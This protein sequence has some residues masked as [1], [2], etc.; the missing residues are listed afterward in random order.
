MLPENSGMLDELVGEFPGDS[1]YSESPSLSTE[2]AANV[3]SLSGLAANL[4]V[5]YGPSV[6]CAN[7]EFL[8]PFLVAAGV[9]MLVR[10]SW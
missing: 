7:F 1:I 4:V 3:T 8:L 9:A 5:A 6:G 10:K 2:L